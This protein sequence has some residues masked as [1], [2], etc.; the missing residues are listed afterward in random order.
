MVL[1][2]ARPQSG[3]HSL[4]LCPAGQFQ[5]QQGPCRRQAGRLVSSCRSGRGSSGG[6]AVVSAAAQ[7]CLPSRPVFLLTHGT[8]SRSPQETPPK[9]LSTVPASWLARPGASGDTGT[10]ASSHL[11]S[12][13]WTSDPW[14][15]KA[16]VLPTP[17]PTPYGCRGPPSFTGP[18]SQETPG[19]CWHWPG[20]FPLG[21]SCSA[22]SEV[23]EAE[24][25]FLG[26]C[27]VSLLLTDGWR[28][29][30][31]FTAENCR[32]LLFVR[33]GS[34]GSWFHWQHNVGF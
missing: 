27:M 17:W 7:P 18:T 33:G 15:G 30:G 9:V 20:L 34:P 22:T 28:A 10:P 29:R 19:H 12:S 2:R 3:F 14:T 1:L 13:S 26:S 25:V 16:G 8:I 21:G 31:P 32:G 23:D 11:T 6:D 5:S 4:C 24:P